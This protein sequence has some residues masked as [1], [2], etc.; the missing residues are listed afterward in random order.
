MVPIPQT[1]RWPSTAVPNIMLSLVEFARLRH[2]ETGAHL[3]RMSHMVG[4]LAL[5]HGFA[6]QQIDIIR[7]S[8]ALHDIGK[9]AIADAILN[10]AGGLDG[11][12]WRIVKQ[13]PAVGAALLPTSRSPLMRCARQVALSHH[14]HW[15]GSGYPHGLN[16]ESIPLPAR[17]VTLCDQY[18]ALR[19]VRPYKPA[20]DHATACRILFEGDD[21]SRP[22]HFDPRLL[23][24]FRRVHPHFET[25][26]QRMQERGPVAPRKPRSSRLQEAVSQPALGDEV[27]GRGGNRLDLPAQSM[28][29]DG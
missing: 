8:A 1:R 28:D 5:H 14:E 3:C 15:D 24:L 12:E 22:E 25:L 6:D 13:H 20:Y 9:I 4:L 10:K 27:A 7:A 16:G 17:M 23:E 21:R 11:D 26:W 2:L 19:S 18:D 29:Q